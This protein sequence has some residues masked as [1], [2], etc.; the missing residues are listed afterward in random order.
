M[1]GSKMEKKKQM[2]N[3]M[4]TKYKKKKKKKKKQTSREKNQKKKMLSVEM[5]KDR[6][7]LQETGDPNPSFIWTSGLRGP[8]NSG[9]SSFSDW[10]VR[11]FQFVR[12]EEQMNF[13]FFLRRDGFLPI[14]E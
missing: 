8:S 2:K 4:K 1:K 7:V 12:S 9:K 3:K 11:Y 6:T 14:G 5:T 10:H 13:A